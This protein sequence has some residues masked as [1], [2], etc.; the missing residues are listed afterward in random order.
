MD[1]GGRS[2][3]IFSEYSATADSRDLS[4]IFKYPMSVREIAKQGGTADIIR[5]CD[6]YG[7][8]TGFL[9]FFGG[10]YDNGFAMACV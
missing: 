4:R 3:R 5:P 1:R 8:V 7:T 2:Q 9:F 10:N 6:R